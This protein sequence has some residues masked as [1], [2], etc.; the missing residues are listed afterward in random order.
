[1]YGFRLEYTC[2]PPDVTSPTVLP[3]GRPSAEPVNAWSTAKTRTFYPFEFYVR[4]RVGRVILVLRGTS[5]SGSVGKLHICKRATD[6]KRFVFIARRAIDLAAGNGTQIA[7]Q[8]RR[9]RTTSGPTVSNIL[10][11]FRRTATLCRDSEDRTEIWRAPA[12][13]RLESEPGRP[14]GRAKSLL[15]W[16]IISAL[17]VRGKR[18]LRDSKGTRVTCI[19]AVCVHELNVK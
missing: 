13:R 10:I 17:T 14:E 5:G 3:F 2:K 11:G 7:R 6:I 16:L 12:S 9:F 1:M 15:L 4:A 8:S 18:R 19:A